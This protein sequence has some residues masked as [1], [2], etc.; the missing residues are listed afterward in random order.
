MNFD[1]YDLDA[2]NDPKRL[3]IGIAAATAFAIGI[4]AWVMGMVETWYVGPLGKLIGDS[5][6]D[7]SNEFTFIITALVYIPAR[8]FE[9][10]IIGR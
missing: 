7:I 4:I 8:Y 2:W 6:G 10:K 3:P 5:G 9:K 1:N